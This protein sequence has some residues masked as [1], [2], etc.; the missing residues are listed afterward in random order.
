MT[1][2]L[3]QKLREARATRDSVVARFK[4]QL[5]TRRINFRFTLH[6]AHIPNRN[7]GSVTEFVIFS[8]RLV[9]AQGDVNQ[10][11]KE[12]YAALRAAGQDIAHRDI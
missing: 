7:Y 4:E 12:L 11:K 9:A 2:L 3:E 1:N 8:H 10:A 5:N 6:D